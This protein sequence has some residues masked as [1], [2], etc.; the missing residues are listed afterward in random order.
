[1]TEEFSDDVMRET[2]QSVVWFSAAW[3]H[4]GP[5]KIHSGEI[6][7]DGS[8]EWH[9]DFAEWLTEDETTKRTR[10]VMKRLRRA[11]VREYEVCYRVLVLRD[12]LDEATVWL[13]ER[14]LKNQIDYPAHRPDG[15]HYIRKDTL[16]L[17]VAGL[18]Y[19]K[20]YW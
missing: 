5:M 12:T 4:E 2:A 10:K 7:A 8:K 15:P 18:S 17:L 9:P 11:A 13:N 3:S 6:A 20:Q 14:A 19:A 1:V 16:A